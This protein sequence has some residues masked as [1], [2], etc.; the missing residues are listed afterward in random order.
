MARQILRR[1]APVL[2]FL[3]ISVSALSA[4]AETVYVTKTGAKYHR[5]GCVSLRSS[6]IPMPLSEA[7]GKYG[8]CKICKPPVPGAAPPAAAAPAIAVSSAPSPAPVER[9]VSSARCQATKKGTQCSRSAKP[10]S[11]YC[12]QHGGTE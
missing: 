5:A 2:A 12:W 10:G 6:S 7:A 3:L 9:A 8:A 11:S 1:L 4:Q